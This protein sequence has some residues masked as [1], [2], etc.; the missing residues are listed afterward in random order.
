[1][2]LG[3]VMKTLLLVGASI[4]AIV[5]LNG[6]Q[7]ADLPV[8]TKAPKAAPYNWTGLYVG[9]EG[10]A[11]W[12]DAKNTRAPGFD[13]LSYTPNG[14]FVGGTIGYNWQ[15]PDNWVV[16]LEGDAAWADVSASTP[17]NT[18]GT[19]CGG[20]NP[21]CSAKFESLETVRARLGYSTGIVLPYITGGVAIAELRGTE[22]DVAANGANGSGTTTDVGWVVGAGFESVV[23]PRWT[24]KLEGLYADFGTKQVFNVTNVP[25]VAGAVPE[26]IK[27]NLG[28]IKIGVNYKLW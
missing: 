8:Y 11:A 10:G 21:K 7:A 15:F 18:F 14:A 4:A 28:I 3:L 17:G 19:Q 24:V 22:G 12:G 5:A 6:A 1:M 23:L 25:G 26:S 16:G 13:S 27:T 20:L 9:F 2:G